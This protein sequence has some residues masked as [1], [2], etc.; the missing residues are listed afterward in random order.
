MNEDSRKAAER[1]LDNLGTASGEIYQDGRGVVVRLRDRAM[2]QPALRFLKHY[3]KCPFE[4]L[5]H[6]S[7]IDWLR[8]KERTG[9]EK[10]RRFTVFYNLY[11]LSQ[12]AR[13]FLELD[14]EEGEALPSASSI[15]ASA[16]WAER[17]VYDLFGIS[18][19]GHPDLRRIFL[20]EDFEGHP[21]RK[22]FPCQGQPAQDWP[23]E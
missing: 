8:W 4:L 11:S 14:L 6:L 20:P 22:D 16:N 9:Q 12:R 21:L 3:E 17:E 1:L 10:A 18:F 7:A 2:L 5:A 15:Y 13:L 19:E 23:Q